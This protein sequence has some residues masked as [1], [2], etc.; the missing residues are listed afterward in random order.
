MKKKRTTQPLPSLLRVL[1]LDGHSRA[2]V[3]TVQSL[4]RA[5]AHVTV[6]A[7]S[8]DALAFASRHAKRRFWQPSGPAVLADWLG[9]DPTEVAKGESEGY[10]Q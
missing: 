4:G 8:D 3:E 9:L 5:G 1:V 7:A 6:A 10:L 2:A